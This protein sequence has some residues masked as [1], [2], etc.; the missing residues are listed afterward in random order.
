MPLCKPELQQRLFIHRHFGHDLDAIFH[1]DAI[2]RCNDGLATAGGDE[3]R[4]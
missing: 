4:A 3:S 2:D 1:G